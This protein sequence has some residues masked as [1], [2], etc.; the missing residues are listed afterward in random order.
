MLSA[1]D[2]VPV[3]AKTPSPIS[4]SPNLRSSRVGADGGVAVFASTAPLTGFDNTD[5]ESG[6]AD[7][8]IFRYDAAA[9]GG[10]GRLDCVSCN[11]SGVRPSGK[12]GPHYTRFFWAAAKIP[13]HEMSTYAS[14]VLSTDGSRLFFE[15]FEAL[16]PRDTNAK[17][18]VYEWQEPGS[19]GCTQA[20]PEHS[21]INGGCVSLI[22]SGRSSEDTAFVDASADGKD[23]F[24]AT[25]SSLFPRTPA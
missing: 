7:R 14:R 24:I 16:T 10:A 20:S 5:A 4:V 22:S 3:P 17:Q 12:L 6:K 19:G 23:V 21:P 8:E 11:P 15:S 13:A 25:A 18:D 9:D 2:D 1:V